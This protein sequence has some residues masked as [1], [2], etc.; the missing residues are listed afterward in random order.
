MAANLKFFS[1]ANFNGCKIIHNYWPPFM[2]VVYIQ[3]QMEDDV[4][5]FPKKIMHF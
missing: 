5:M 2:K 4:P 1:K 3:N